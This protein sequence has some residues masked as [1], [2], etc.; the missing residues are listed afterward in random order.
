ML[1]RI[2]PT[3]NQYLH[4][5]QYG[6]RKGRNTQGAGIVLAA[7][8]GMGMTKNE[9]TQHGLTFTAFI[10]I[11][12]AYP[13]MYRPAMLTKLKKAGINGY[14]FR[15]VES[16]YHTVE[17]YI[18][19]DD[20][21]SDKYQIET[22][23]RE[24]SVLSPILYSVFINDLLTEIYNA[25]EGACIAGDNTCRVD[26]I[27]YADD[28]VLVSTT[29]DGLQRQLDIVAK[30]A[31]THFFQV[32]QSKSKV[33]VFGDQSTQHPDATR[34]HIDGLYNDVDHLDPDHIAETDRYEYLGTWFHKNRT[35]KTQFEEAA[36]KFWS[37]TADKWQEAG[38]IRMG[39]GELV[40]K[41]LWESLITPV[42]DYD[43][44]V[45]VT[46]H[47]N[48]T[49]RKTMKPLDDV[50]KAARQAVTG[51]REHCNQAAR[52][53]TGIHDTDTRRS[54]RCATAVARIMKNKENA[55]LQKVIR[56]LAHGTAGCRRAKQAIRHVEKIAGTTGVAIGQRKPSTVHAKDVREDCTDT[57]DHTAREQASTHTHTREAWVLYKAIKH[58]HGTRHYQR[59]SYAVIT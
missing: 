3:V 4:T 6:F 35:W 13:T 47:A 49:V 59:K 41:T 31:K 56:H 46:A 8:A 44:L 51:G 36:K 21:A 48:K 58:T 45:T 11:R 17:S 28:L 29:A 9:Q 20:A 22:G 32:S 19:V 14:L 5:Q 18:Q 25:G 7:A 27:G 42:I 15:A 10:D 54:A 38:A 50:T 52:M 33:V 30:Y 39:A 16:M 34:W 43:P 26:V 40:A 1:A 37:R 12:K 23:L 2:N 55:M 57:A 24:G 53:A